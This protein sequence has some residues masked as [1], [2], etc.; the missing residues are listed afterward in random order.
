MNR[1]LTGQVR[2][3]PVAAISL[4]VL[5][6]LL[7]PGYSSLT[8]HISELG[9]LPSASGLVMRAGAII[10]GVSV[11]VFGVSLLFLQPQKMTFTGLTATLFGISYASGGVF[12]SGDPLHGLYGM[13][14]LYVLIPGF[15]AAEAPAS[16]RSPLLVNVSLVMALL[17]LFYMWLMGSGFEPHALRGVTQRLALAVIFGWH[18]FAGYML[19]RPAKAAPPCESSDLLAADSGRTA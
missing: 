4:V 5:A 14:M 1:F 13:T 16:V 18:A 15:F 17:A 12:P 11:A 19:L 8:Q 2:I 10:A 6:G 3:V 7:T 9:L